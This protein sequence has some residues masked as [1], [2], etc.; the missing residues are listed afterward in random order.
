MAVPSSTNQSQN[1]LNTTFLAGLVAGTINKFVTFPF[2]TIKA[3]IQ[4]H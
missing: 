3:K 4:V 1:F 2:D